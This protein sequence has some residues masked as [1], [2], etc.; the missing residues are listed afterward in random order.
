[1]VLSWK[2]LIFTNIEGE[3][4]SVFNI[5]RKMNS[6]FYVPQSPDVKDVVHSIWQIDR[7]SSFRKE[8]IIPKGV[9]EIIFNFSDS[10]PISAHLGDKQYHLPNCFISGFNTAPI[11]LQ[12]SKKQ[13]FFGVTL[14]PLAAKKI[15]G[16]PASAFSDI[17]VDLTLLSS[18]F[19]N[20]W[21][22]L[23]DENN[24]DSESVDLFPLDTIETIRLARAGKT[25]EPFLMRYQSA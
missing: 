7:L 2:Y 11:R 10:S 25:D 4:K 24:F 9:V 14:Q 1:M 20:L 21:H 13:V 6:H 16:A 22:E 18:T 23:A 15:L 5:P 12:L 3:L 19:N 8:H 17:L